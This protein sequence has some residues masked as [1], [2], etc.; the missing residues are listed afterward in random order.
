MQIFSDFNWD[1]KLKNSLINDSKILNNNH[2][3]RWNDLLRE[4]FFGRVLLGVVSRFHSAERRCGATQKIS[5]ITQSSAS[6]FFLFLCKSPS[7]FLLRYLKR[8]PKNRPENVTKRY[9]SKKNF[10]KYVEF[11][12]YVFKKLFI[13]TKS[14]FFERFERIF[15][16]KKS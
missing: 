3:I 5:R 12:F 16:L 8:D 7:L 2:F 11:L 6:I 13:I 14:Y 9:S 4:G 1:I 10:F 15:F